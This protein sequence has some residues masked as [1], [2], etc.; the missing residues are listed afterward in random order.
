MLTGD[1]IGEKHSGI[2]ENTTRIQKTVETRNRLRMANR[3][4][5]NKQNISSQSRVMP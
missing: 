4:K 2:F 3:T 1:R 5:L